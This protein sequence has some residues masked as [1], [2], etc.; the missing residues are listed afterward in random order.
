MPKF[1]ERLRLL[2]TSRGLS[3][4]DL[5]KFLGISKSSVNMYERGEREPGLETLEAIGDFFNVDMDYLHGKSDVENR[6][7]ID[8]ASPTSNDKMTL[9]ELIENYRTEHDLSQ[10]QFALMCGLSN[11]YISMLERGFNPKTK[12]PIVPTLPK[13]MQL[14]QGLGITVSEIFTLVDDIQ[15]DLSSAD[16]E[17]LDEFKLLLDEVSLLKKYRRLDDYGKETVNLITDRELARVEAAAT[18]EAQ[19]LQRTAQANVL[20]Y[21]LLNLKTTES[22][23]PLAPDHPNSNLRVAE[24]I[25]PPT[26]ETPSDKK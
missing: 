15:I 2:R 24:P 5:A 13:I 1:N 10:R 7:R 9:G 26:P 14:A 12:L 4:S 25:I 21:D 8:T 19:P 18:D 20:Q 22:G 11:G 17:N 23:L 3:Q 6:Y 16:S